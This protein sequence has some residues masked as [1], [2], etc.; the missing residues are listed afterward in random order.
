MLP[1]MASPVALNEFIPWLM[2]LI[3]QLSQFLSGDSDSPF[4][5]VEDIRVV[6]WV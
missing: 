6:W 2:E 1:Y 4:C 3:A 5:A